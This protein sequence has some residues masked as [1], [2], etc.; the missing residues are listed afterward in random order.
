MQRLQ[1]EHTSEADLAQEEKGGKNKLQQTLGL[2]MRSAL[3]EEIEK[4]CQQNLISDSTFTWPHIQRCLEDMM[5]EMGIS[6]A[7]APISG[8]TLVPIRLWCIAPELGHPLIDDNHDRPLHPLVGPFL[9]GYLS[10]HEDIDDEDDEM[11]HFYTGLCDTRVL[12]RTMLEDWETEPAADDNGTGKTIL[13]LGPSGSIMNRRVGAIRFH[14]EP[15]SSNTS[16][17]DVT[18]TTFQGTTSVITSRGPYQLECARWHLLTKIFSNPESFRA[19]LH[20][21]LL[22][23]ERLD[24]NIKYRYFSWQIL[25]EAS[26]FSGAK[27]YI[28]ETGLTTP[29]F[30]SNA[31]RGAKIMWGALDDSPV[32]VNWNGLD[33]LEQADITPTLQ[34]ANNWIIFTHPLGPEK[35]A[36]PPIPSGAQRILYTKGK[37]GRERGWWRTGMDKRASNGLDTEVW[38]SQDSTI[39]DSNILA[40][41]ALLQTK[42]EKDLPDMRSDRVQLMYWAGTESGLMD[43]YNFPGVIYATDGS[44]GS[45][46]MGAGFYR[47]DTNDDD[48]FYYHSWRNNVV[49]AFGTLSSFL[50]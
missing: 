29:L 7:D 1:G 34:A 3:P 22:L 36:T 14:H 42:S 10:R 12:A 26:E 28:G 11:G 2:V 23:Q 49:I 40:L 31:R 47:H 32:I 8:V 20:S 39:S 15:E 4:I 27:T 44:K 25:R 5:Q 6:A 35:S 33:L 37:A 16:R 50:T 48:F 41:E 21:E 30:F 38:I 43:I 24:E 45:M 46:G 9:R 17:A 19:D 18:A 13:R